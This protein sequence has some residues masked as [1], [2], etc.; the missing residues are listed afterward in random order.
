MNYGLLRENIVKRQ[1]ARISIWGKSG[2]KQIMK[3][4]PSKITKKSPFAK[5]NPCKKTRM[6]F[7]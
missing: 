4:N 3:I 5:I 6:A 1:F 2:N 7:F